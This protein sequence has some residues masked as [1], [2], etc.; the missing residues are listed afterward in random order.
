MIATQ[1]DNKDVQLWAVEQ[2]GLARALGRRLKTN[3]AASRAF[4]HAQRQQVVKTR[5]ARPQ[6][7]GRQGVAIGARQEGVFTPRIGHQAL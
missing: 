4:D 5:V 3:A 1:G 7:A 6:R 2:E